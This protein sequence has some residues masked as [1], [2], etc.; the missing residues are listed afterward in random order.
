MRHAGSMAASMLL[1]A[2][3]GSGVVSSGSGRPAA[4]QFTREVSAVP[5]ELVKAAVKVFG[6]YGIPIAE[7]DE[8]DGRMR[9]AGVNLRSL[10]RRFDEAPLACA[11]DTPRDADA[12]VTFDLRVRRTDNGS[13]MTLETKRAGKADCVVRSQFVQALLDEIA[14]AAGNS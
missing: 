7:S 6:R 12:Q 4:Q 1:M 11:Q 2:A 3:C 9:T 14:A 13:A 8:P 10:A 5:T